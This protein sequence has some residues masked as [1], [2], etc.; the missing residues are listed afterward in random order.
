[1]KRTLE[2]GFCITG[3]YV[4]FLTWGVLQERLATTN[5]A[6]VPFSNHGIQHGSSVFGSTVSAYLASMPLLNYFV[7]VSFLMYLFDLFLWLYSEIMGQLHTA[8]C[9]IISFVYTPLSWTSNGSSPA[10]TFESFVLLNMVQS[11][12]SVIIAFFMLRVR[13]GVFPWPTLNALKSLALEFLNFPLWQVVKHYITFGRISMHHLPASKRREISSSH[14]S[15]PLKSSGNIATDKNAK[16]TKDPKDFKDTMKQSNGIKNVPENRDLCGDVEEMSLELLMQYLRLAVCFCCASPFGYASLQYIDYVAMNLGKSCK[17]LPLVLMSVFFRGKRIERAKLVSLLLITAGVTGFML[18]D[19]RN[20]K[21]KNSYTILDDRH[22]LLSLYGLFLLLVNLLLDG[23]MNTFQDEMFSAFRITSLHMMLHMNWM[24]VLLQFLYLASPLTGEL[25]RTLD[26][27]ITYPRLFADVLLFGFCGALG[28]AFVFHTIERFGALSLV[29]VTVTRKL[30][31][32]LL[33]VAYF[34]HSL[35][36]LQWL[37]VAVVFVALTMESVLGK[38][39][40]RIVP[41]SLLPHAL[42]HSSASTSSFD[43]RTKEA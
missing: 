35:A 37:C 2:L 11:I 20:G 15:V 22:W 23:A 30:F 16:I 1:M 18:F 40:K 8:F 32:I 38:H 14:L 43:L 42:P 39:K 34:G 33:S 3:I 24:A 31:T 26:S 4:C 41:A 25:W 29:T 5:Y 17:L 36:P 10:A 19:T 21:G 13:Y 27:L 9:F 7:D 12:G 28:Q 6:A